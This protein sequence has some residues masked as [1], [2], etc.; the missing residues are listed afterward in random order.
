MAVLD[1]RLL[2]IYYNINGP[3]AQ[4]GECS[5]RIRKVEGS[6]PLRSTKRVLDEHL[7][8]QRRVCRQG[9]ALIRTKNAILDECLRWRFSVRG[10]V[11]NCWDFL[12]WKALNLETYGN[13]FRLEFILKFVDFGF[14][15]DNNKV[16]SS[17]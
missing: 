6:I 9:F 8:F 16:L 3:V 11:L 2:K 15:N 4:P 12:H 17:S 5:V 7:L 10:T 1:I 13:Q 14:I